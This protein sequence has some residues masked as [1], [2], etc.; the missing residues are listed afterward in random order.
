[1]VNL[2][3]KKITEKAI[4]PSTG[5]IWKIEDVPIRWRELVREALEN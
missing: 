2:Y 4:N 5:E 3:I 1:M